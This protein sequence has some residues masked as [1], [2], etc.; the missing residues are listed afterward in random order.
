MCACKHTK[1]QFSFIFNTHTHTH[2][3]REFDDQF[4]SHVK[5][6]FVFKYIWVHE[7]LFSD[8]IYT[9]MYIGICKL[10]ERKKEHRQRDTKTKHRNFVTYAD[11]MLFSFSYIQFS[12]HIIFAFG[13]KLYT[14]LNNTK[15]ERDGKRKSNENYHV[16]H[17]ICAQDEC[18]R[19]VK[20]LYAK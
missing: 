6:S 18:C 12:F 5:I 7:N 3:H 13:I 10:N 16:R 4:S 15:E 19:L 20:L 2:T 1:N 11:N 14:N 8:E 17:D 9:R